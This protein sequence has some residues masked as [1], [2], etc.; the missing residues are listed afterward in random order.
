LLG[1]EIFL[2]KIPVQFANATGRVSMVAQ[3][4]PRYLETAEESS[5]QTMRAI[6]EKVA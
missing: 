1:R 5:Q 4:V 2:S 6:R 3:H